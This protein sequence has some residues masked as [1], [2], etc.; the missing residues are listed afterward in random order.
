M[1]QSW[2]NLPTNT[3]LWGQISNTYMKIPAWLSG[4]VTLHWELE[5]S[6]SQERLGRQSSWSDELQAQWETP[7]GDLD[8]NG[9]HR[10]TCLTTRF[11]VGGTIREG[12]KGVVFLEKVCH[13]WVGF[14]GSKPMAFQV[15]HPTT[16][17]C[18]MV[19]SHDVC[20]QLRHQDHACLLPCSLLWWKYI[21]PLKL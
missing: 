11:Q 4:P 13:W 14:E 2:E 9:P 6:G 8:E 1:S 20:S 15:N 21:Y 12:F 3:S 5:T 7:D 10:L 17:L 19:M 18:Y 16:C